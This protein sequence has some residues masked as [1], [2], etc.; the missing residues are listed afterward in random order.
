[1]YNSWFG[2]E[3]FNKK[4]RIK[5]NAVVDRI[6]VGRLKNAGSSDAIKEALLNMV[7]VLYVKP[8]LEEGWV[9]VEHDD[10]TDTQS[11]EA[12]LIEVIYEIKNAAPPIVCNETDNTDRPIQWVL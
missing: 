8:N 11:I 7:G 4:K 3:F 6:C 10:F 5:M 1:M 12:R 9:D 2:V